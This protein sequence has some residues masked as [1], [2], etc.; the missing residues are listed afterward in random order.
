[1]TLEFCRGFYGG[2]Y[3]AENMHRTPPEGIQNPEFHEWAL[4]EWGLRP[5]V[6]AITD[7]AVSQSLCCYRAIYHPSVSLISPLTIS[8]L[9]FQ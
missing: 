6:E 2:M 7:E 1:M 3:R 9:L 4:K 8:I 5:G